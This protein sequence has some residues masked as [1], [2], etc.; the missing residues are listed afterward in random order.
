[1]ATYHF[2]E[3][4]PVSEMELSN[5]STLRVTLVPA[6]DGRTVVGLREWVDKGPR[7]YSGPTKRGFVLS[8]TA[9]EGLIVALKRA[10]EALVDDGVPV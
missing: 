7:R 3:E 6:S 8:S 5:S 10:Q 9:L 2:D 1:M 4:V